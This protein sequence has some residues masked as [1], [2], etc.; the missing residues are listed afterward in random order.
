MTLRSGSRTLRGDGRISVPV[1]PRITRRSAGS[2]GP[3]TSEA[4]R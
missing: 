1:G 3:R 2:T 4:S